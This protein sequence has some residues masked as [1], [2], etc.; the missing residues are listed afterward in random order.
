MISS[1]DVSALKPSRSA[2]DASNAFGQPSMILMIAG[3]GS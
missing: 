1:N 2:L 3:S